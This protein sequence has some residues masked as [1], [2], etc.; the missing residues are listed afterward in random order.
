MDYSKYEGHTDGWH[1]GCVQSITDDIEAILMPH[2][3][4]LPDSMSD[5]DAALI[6]DA[7]ALLAR[8]KE[9]EAENV[10]L[11]KRLELIIEAA[12]LYFRETSSETEY[13]QKLKAALNA[14]EKP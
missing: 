8:C 11:R 14:L 4:H 9:L 13:H 6:A 3:I 2:C 12:K 7:P 5:A 10:E 1:I